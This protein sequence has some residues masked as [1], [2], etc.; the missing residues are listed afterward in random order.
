M[1][2]LVPLLI[3]IVIIVA[4]VVFTLRVRLRSP[5][6]A[7]NP[8]PQEAPIAPDLDSIPPDSVFLGELLEYREKTAADFRGDASPLDETDR[9]AFR[10]LSYFPADPAYCLRV[11]LEP[12]PG[13]GTI[14]LM[15]TKGRERV[16]ERMGRLRFDMDGRPQQLTLFREPTL[17]YYFLPFRDA[18]TGHETYEVGRYV[19]PVDVGEGRVFLIDFNRAYNPY[20]AYSHRWSCPIPPPE[21]QLTVPIRAGEMSYRAPATG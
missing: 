18:T 11:P 17:H 21:N 9:L 8:T 14:T 12:D 16:F 3:L 13:R 4:A 10:G 6:P 5:S 19:E 20:C 15:D 7:S 2:R 1:K